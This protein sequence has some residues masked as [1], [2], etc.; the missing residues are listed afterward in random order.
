VETDGGA[1]AAPIIVAFDIRAA[2]EP[3]ALVVTTEK[4]YDTPKVSPEIW[5]V[6]DGA[7]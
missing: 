1:D 3:D 5:Q 7:L 2:L 4:V 6:A